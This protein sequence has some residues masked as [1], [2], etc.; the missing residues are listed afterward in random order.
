M[1]TN[2][3]FPLEMFSSPRAKLLPLGHI[4]PD[5]GL[6]LG[7]TVGAT[8]RRGLRLKPEYRELL[9]DTDLLLGDS[10]GT[11][12][13]RA[14]L[15]WMSNEG[16]LAPIAAEAPAAVL[17]LIPV[18]RHSFAAVDDLEDD[19]YRLHASNGSVFILEELEA[20]ILQKVDGASA[21]GD[22]ISTVYEDL[23]TSEQNRS[24]IAESEHV[25]KRPYKDTLARAALSLTEKL[26]RAGVATVD[27]ASETLPDAA[28]KR[29]G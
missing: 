3:Q 17:D 22:L 6:T 28:P 25:D 14:L 12:E 2:S 19:G 16:V 7:D 21:F 18:L 27:R 5:G 23:L 8:N 4:D 1:S 9:T 29:A 13:Q 10:Y 15:W 11:P 20:R 24:A 26:L